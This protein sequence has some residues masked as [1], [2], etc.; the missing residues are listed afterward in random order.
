MLYDAFLSLCVNVPGYLPFTETLVFAGSAHAEFKQLVF[1]CVEALSQSSTALSAVCESVVAQLLP[2][3]LALLGSENG[4]TRFL[5]LKIFTDI[6]SAYLSDRSIYDPAA[7]SGP[8]TPTFATTKALNE[9]LVTNFLA[10]CKN[11]LADKEPIPQV[12]SRFLGF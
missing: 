5:S 9:L 11:I 7:L 8:Q 2:A 4:D 1:S 10:K 12:C 3:L 6:C